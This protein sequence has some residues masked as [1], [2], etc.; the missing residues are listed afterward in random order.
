MA[1]LPA[2]EN[3]TAAPAS[4]SLFDNDEPTLF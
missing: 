3:G 4:P 2:Q 1:L